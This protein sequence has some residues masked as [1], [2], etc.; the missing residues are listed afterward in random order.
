ML[1]QSQTREHRQTVSFDTQFSPMPALSGISVG[2]NSRKVYRV[3]K[4]RV[5]RP[6]SS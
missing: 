3:T 1:K 4:E 6:N 5:C 2:V